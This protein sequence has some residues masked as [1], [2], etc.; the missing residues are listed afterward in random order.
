M[1]EVPLYRIACVC[2]LRNAGMRFTPEVGR[3]PLPFFFTLVTGPRRSLSLKLS[4]TRVRP[5]PCAFATKSEFALSP[6]PDTLNPKPK[7]R[8]PKPETRNPKPKTR[9]PKPE[10]RNPKPETRNPKS[11]TRNPEP[12][13]ETLNSRCCG[14]RACTS[15]GGSPLWK[16]EKSPLE[17]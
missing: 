15:S 3:P 8:N 12:N 14:G 17:S 11:Q 2:A 9:N 13:P 1:S 10:T 7:T 16:V 6:Q 4:D 5:Y